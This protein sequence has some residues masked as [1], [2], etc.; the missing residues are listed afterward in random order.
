M[1][2]ATVASTPASAAGERRRHQHEQQQE[3]G[4]EYARQRP[5]RA[6]ADVGRRARDQPGH[7]DAAEQRRAD[8]GDAL[9]HQLAI[10][11]VPPAGHAV[12]DHR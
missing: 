9:R 1:F 10:R 3:G 7:A 8:I 11:A 6:G 5:M 2:H 4:M 12:R